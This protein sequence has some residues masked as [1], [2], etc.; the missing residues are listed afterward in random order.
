VSSPRFHAPDATGAG[1]IVLST[2]ESHHLS[3]VLRLGAGAAVR[4]FDGR[5]HEWDAR[6]ESASGRR[7]MVRLGAA[8]EPVAEPPVRVTLAIGLLKGDQMD[9]VMRDA[10]AL[11][12]SA[13]A[14]IVT[15]FTA[16]A[17]SAARRDGARDRWRRVVLAAAK[18]CRRAVLPEVTAIG[19]LSQ[20]LAVAGEGAV[21]IMAVEPSVTVAPPGGGAHGLAALAAGDRPPTSALVAIGPEGGWSDAEIG[22][23]RE[24]D[25]RALSLGPRTLRAETAPTVVLAVLWTRWG[26]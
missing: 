8:V 21:V 23:A 19:D 15:A 18:Q 13:I 5:G 25:A 7:A 20:A 16:V 17:R 10:T 3:R 12:V 1:P 6:V 24:H 9:A 22:W 26:W 2:D 11:G 14:P 4:V